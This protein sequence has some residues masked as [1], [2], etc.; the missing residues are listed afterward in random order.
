MEQAA[1]GS[2]GVPNPGGIQEQCGRATKGYSSVMRLDR[3]VWWL[4][5]VILK[6]IYSLDHSVIVWFYY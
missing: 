2:C 6:V 4:D 1:Q 3:S 5:F